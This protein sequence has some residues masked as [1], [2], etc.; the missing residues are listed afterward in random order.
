MKEKDRKNLAAA[1]FKKSLFHINLQELSH[2]TLKPLET[3]HC[4]TWVTYINTHTHTYIYIDPYVYSISNGNK[5]KERLTGEDASFLAQL[6]PNLC[7]STERCYA[8]ILT[9]TWQ[10][11]KWL[12]S[13]VNQEHL[14]ACWQASQRSHPPHV[15]HRL[16]YK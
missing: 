2:W 15:S 10:L 8:I 3:S 14:T 7:C 12:M 5:E 13:G 11:H 4:L 16:A 1:T 9:N 6:T